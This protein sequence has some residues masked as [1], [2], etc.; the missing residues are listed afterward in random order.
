[1]TRKAALFPGKYDLSHL[2]T[3]R[4]LLDFDEAYTAPA[5]GYRSAAD[6]YEQ[7]GAR[8]VLGAIARPTLIITAQDDP[9]IPYWIFDVPA[10]HKNPHI[11][12]VA[13][14]HGGHCGFIQRRMPGEDR[15]WAENRLVAFVAD[16]CRS[17]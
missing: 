1:M 7:T 6:Y 3:I 5:G 16:T 10:L 12:L 13:P 9:F 4:T 17:R 15:Y 2:A 14:T 11:R 8:H